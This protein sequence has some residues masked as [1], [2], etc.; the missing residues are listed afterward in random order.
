MATFSPIGGGYL[1]GNDAGEFT[2]Y[3]DLFEQGGRVAGPGYIARWSAPDARPLVDGLEAGFV[4]ANDPEIGGIG[5]PAWHH[6]RANGEAD[7]WKR[8]WEINPLRRAP[9]GVSASRV[10]DAPRLDR[11][12]NVRASFEVDFADLYGPVMSVRHDYIVEQP[13]LRVW[14]TFTQRWDGTSFPA[15]LKEPK[16]TVG[17][18]ASFE[19]VELYDAEGK[20]QRRDD[21]KPLQNPARHTL[22]LRPQARTRA[23]FLPG[24]V[25]LVACAAERHRF[26]ADGPVSRYGVRRTWVGSGRG[27]DGWAEAAN[28]RQV[29]EQAN[30]K[31][32]CLQGPGGTLSRNWE[33]AKRGEAPISLMFHAW[34]GGYGLPDCLACARAFGRQDESWTA[35][36]CVS[37]GEGWRA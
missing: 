22:Q 32:Y 26:A 15:F 5:I 6:F 30:T 16:L 36:L 7:I 4:S 33:I 9:C 31:P 20:R 13:C 29:F 8:G 23:R 19:T 35:Y 24:D 34:E 12:G 1:L 25:N 28:T 11:Y 37:L 21:L 18:V 10:V 14:I 3:T 2:V 27:L 17:F